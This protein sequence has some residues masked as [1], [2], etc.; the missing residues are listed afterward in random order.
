MTICKTNQ[1]LLLHRSEL[2]EPILTTD[3]S[4]RFEEAAAQSLV[5][6]QHA[7]LLRLIRQLPSSNQTLLAWTL[8]HF[9]AVIQHEQRNR[10]NAQSLAVLLSPVLQM[11]HRLLVC[12][13]C[14]CST[15]FEGVVLAK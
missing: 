1:L 7:D 11:S 12:M 13:L 9:D 6:Q 15:L 5:A 8:C 3:L 14:H 10:T 2:P 4:V